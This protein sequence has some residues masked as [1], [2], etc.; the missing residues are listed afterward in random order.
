MITL[1]K[2]LAILAILVVI[3]GIIWSSQ[4][5]DVIVRDITLERVATSSTATKESVVIPKNENSEVKATKPVVQKKVLTVQDAWIVFQNYIES[6]HNHDLPAFTKAAYSLSSV[7]KDANQQEEC[8]RRMDSVYESGKKLTR[9]SYTQFLYDDTQAMLYTDAQ[10][11]STETKISLVRGYIYFG[12]DDQGI[13]KIHTFDP[14][15]GWNIDKGNLTQ[16]ELEKKLKEI[17]IDSDSDGLT[18]LEET[19]TDVVGSIVEGC[20]KTDPMKKD[21][22]GDGWWDGVRIF[23]R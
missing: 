6:A 23:L 22:F 1:K 14:N 20:V 2:I 16:A 21:S 3:V 9:N 5:D 18:D 12:I 19:C 8:F 13:L 15:R 7:C 11:K 17:S 4:K 10:F